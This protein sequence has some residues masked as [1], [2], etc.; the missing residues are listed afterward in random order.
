DRLLGGVLAADRTARPCAAGILRPA[1][2]PPAARYAGAGLVGGGVAGRRSTGGDWHADGPAVA[3]RAVPAASRCTEPARRA[4]ALA[5]F[6]A[7]ALAA[8]AAADAGTPPRLQ[9]LAARAGAQ[10]RCRLNRS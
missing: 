1:L 8:H 4:G 6:R 5:A 3:G 9:G 2:C 10:H 7:P